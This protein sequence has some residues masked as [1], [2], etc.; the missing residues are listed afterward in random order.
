MQVKLRLILY[1]IVSLGF[2]KWNSSLRL[3]QV[4]PVVYWGYSGFILFDSHLGDFFFLNNELAYVIM[5][6]E[7]SKICSQ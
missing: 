3:D 1:L 5:E 6:A 4:E 7:M 2:L